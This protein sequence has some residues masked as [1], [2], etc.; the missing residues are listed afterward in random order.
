MNTL[1]K[2]ICLWILIAATA[3][4]VGTTGVTAAD[5]SADQIIKELDETVAPARDPAKSQ[6]KTSA[7]R[8]LA[9]RKE[10]WS[11]RDTLILQLYKAAPDHARL[12]DLMPE[13]WNRKLDQS[14]SLIKE[15]DDVLAHN[16]DHKLKMEAT[17]CKARV[18]LRENRFASP[19]TLASVNE[20]LTLAP[21]DPRGAMLLEMAIERARDPKTKA[22][23]ED[24]LA[25][26]FPDTGDGD[27][28]P[29]EGTPRNPEEWVGKPF[30]LKFTDAISGKPI[31]TRRLRGNVIV[32][33][34]WAT[35]CGPCVAEMP[36]MK[37]LYRTYHAQG[38]EFLG[39]SLDQP[40]REGGLTKLKN[41]V[42]TNGI[43]WPQYFQGDG[44]KSKFSS[45]WGVRAIP[46]V[47]V[48]APDGRLYS[49]DARGKLD[50]MIPELLTGKSG[51]IKTTADTGG[52]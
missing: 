24:R 4:V 25:R 18:R 35:W 36:H 5:K 3:G 52:D 50:E 41:F 28:A 8:L 51:A 7:R 14:K 21:A 38:V 22:S 16:K 9:K 31:S 49:A 27:G 23:L 32:V 2:R 19:A 13:R 15:I 47:F 33:D 46:S 6:N 17:F 29:E 42:E 11:K 43:R 44:W 48:I 40:E 12:P 1:V 26:A 10:I 20:F 39:V 34:F 45:A 37:E 30:D